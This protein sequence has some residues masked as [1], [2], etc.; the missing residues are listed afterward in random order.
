MNIVDLPQSADK[1]TGIGKRVPRHDMLRILRGR[2]QYVGDIVLPRMGHL[3]F[4]RSPYAR[5]R[6]LNIDITRALKCPNVMGIFDGHDLARV[7]TPFESVSLNRAGHVAPPQ[8]VMAVD[9]AYWQGQPV[10]AVVASTRAEAEDAAQEVEIE[11]EE[12]PAVVDARQALAAEHV[13]HPSM[14]DNLAF[15]HSI[16]AGTPAATFAAAAT[17]VEQEF[18]FGRQSGLTLEPRGLIADWNEASQSLLVYHSHQSQFQMQDVYSRHLGIPEQRVRVIVPDVGGGFGMKLNVY[19][20]EVA[21][22]A[23]SR[24]LARPVKFCADRLESFVSDT[25]AR[26]HWVKAR[27][28][29]DSKGYISALE[30]DDVAPIGAFGMSMRFNI[31]EGMMT[32]NWSGAPYDIKNYHARTRSLYVN[33]NLIGM[34]RGVGIPIAVAVTE[35][36]VDKA[37][38]QIGMDPVAFRRLNYR[39]REAMPCTLPSGMSMS[40]CSFNECLDKLLD[41]MDYEQLRAEQAELRQQGIYRGIGIA[42]FVEPSAYGPPYYGPTAARISVQDGCTVRLE[43]SGVFR[44]I[45]SIVDMGQGTLIGINQIVADTLGVA[46]TDVE[47]MAGDSALSPYG[48]GAW[49]SRGMAVGGEAALKAATDLKNNILKL[50]GAITQSAP[51][52]LDIVAATVVSRQTG[53]EVI[54]LA[55]VGRIGYFRQDT[56][57]QGIAYELSIT[58]SH[59]A[60]HQPYYTG[61]GVQG[62]YLELDHETGFIKLLGVWAVDDCGRLINP[63]MVEE[64]IRGGIVQGIGAALYEECVYDSHGNLTNATLADYLVPMAAEMPDIHV[65]HVETPEPTTALGAKGIGEAGTIG[66]LGVMWVGVNDALAG[67]GA[68]IDQQPF[69]PERVLD[70]IAKVNAPD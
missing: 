59:V 8:P 58:R 15:D 52:D 16:S 37:A 18:Y 43:P 23:V 63:L 44:C 14:Q 12:L 50:A 26:E 33:K 39:A 31:A 69:T 30:L 22:A 60:H 29:V 38:R 45:T 24:L 57:P 61:N 5:A 7:C 19:A 55:E 62:V 41:A 67:L 3:V 32:I 10:V 21:V 6:I 17:V 56:L 35:Q 48:G 28:A 70:A 1:A 65:D 42:T 9:M 40:G 53:Q 20:E 46:V 64:Q 68:N 27:M 25:Q 13:V 4:V 34:Y 51:E 47:M 36:L 11:W 49:A 54:S 66:A 2:G